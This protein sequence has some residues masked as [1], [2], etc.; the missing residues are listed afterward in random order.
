[1]V[2]MQF[3]QYRW[4]DVVN[5][6]REE[7][8]QLASTYGL[9][10]T[11]VQDC[12]DPEHLPKYEKIGPLHF[13]IMRH[14]DHLSPYS[15][16][17]V[18]ELTRKIAIFY[19]DNFLITVHRVDMPFMERLREKWKDLEGESANGRT[20]QMI[21]TDLLHNIFL[22]Y[23]KPIDQ[24]LNKLEAIEMSIF[25]APGTNPFEIRE[26]YFLKRK[27]SVFKRMLRLSMDVLS[28]LSHLQDGQAPIV[29]DLREMLDSLYFYSDELVESTNSLV[30]LHVSLSSQKT[31][32]ASHRTNEVM[33]V[34]TVF[35]VFVLPLNFIASI[36]GMNFENMPEL[37]HP[38]GYPIVLGVMAAL[39]FA[40]YMWFRKKGWLK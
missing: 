3:G 12:L 33:R 11:S 30:N 16:D 9:H 34:L 22:T 4:L 8:E 25:G 14:Y 36:Y 31:N 35:S 29:Q 17:T 10:P 40:I 20:G 21:L 6:S 23:E 13:I 1:M 32:E 26:G 37:K 5:P 28:K 24:G 27:A 2:T 19:T 7:L 39:T 38:L 15:A 18:Q